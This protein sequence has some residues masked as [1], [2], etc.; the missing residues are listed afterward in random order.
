MNTTT[1]FNRI[2]EIQG[3]VKGY[4]LALIVAV[5]TALFFAGLCSRM[6]GERFVKRSS[7]VRFKLHDMGS[8]RTGGAGM[9]YHLVGQFA[10]AF[11]WL[12]QLRHRGGKSQ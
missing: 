10:D 8:L 9:A 6:V 5:S 4:R 7:A 2:E 1:Y 12:P 11:I 3:T